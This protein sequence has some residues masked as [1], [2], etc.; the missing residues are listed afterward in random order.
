M[1]IKP[2]KI[3][4]EL[5]PLKEH[6]DQ[7][8]KTSAYRVSSNLTALLI[9][10]TST[11][12]LILPLNFCWDKAVPNLRVAQARGWM[13][14]IAGVLRP[15]TTKPRCCGHQTNSPQGIQQGT[16]CT[17][18]SI[19]L[20]KDFSSKKLAGLRQHL[21]FLT[22]G[23]LLSLWD[24]KAAPAPPEQGCKGTQNLDAD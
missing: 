4:C 13:P 8:I 10:F 1:R 9:Y 12:P 18:L 23:L 20:K 16:S 17:S 7:K 21:L 14:P 3:W 6:L 22:K 2:S 19:I 24:T 15:A 11:I 5:V